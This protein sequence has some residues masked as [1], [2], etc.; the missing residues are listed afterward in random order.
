MSVQEI[1][2][3]LDSNEDLKK[4][5]KILFSMT[6]EQR[7]KAIPILLEFINGIKH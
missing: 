3:I 2:E 7:E 5:F 1:K 4:L 6:P